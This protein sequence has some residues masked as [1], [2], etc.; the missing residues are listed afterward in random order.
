MNLSDYLGQLNVAVS[1]LQQEWYERFEKGVRKGHELFEGADSEKQKLYMAIFDK[2]VRTE[3]LKAWYGEPEGAS[4]FQGTSVSSLTVPYEVE[5]PLIL[6]SIEEL[7]EALAS[8]YIDRHD[9]HEKDVIR[10][11]LE[12]V[13][14]WI[15]EGLYYG[16]VLGSKMIS[17]AFGLTAPAKSVVFEVDGQLV[18]PHEITSYP[19]SIR[20]AYFEKSHQQI[21]CFKGVDISQVDFEKSLVL[22]DI[23]KPKI[24]KYQG[25]LM[26]GPVL[27]NEIAAVMSRR[28]V[29]L[30]RDKTSGRISPRSLMV[31]IYDTDTPYT[32]HQVAGY[33]GK[34][35]APTLP[36]LTLLGSSG[37]CDAFKW[38]YIYRCSLLAQKIMKS[39]LYS[40]HA[41]KFI[42]FVFFGVLV[43][44][45]AEILLDLDRLSLL[46]YRGDIS[47][48]LEFCYLLPKIDK[49]LKEVDDFDLAIELKTRIR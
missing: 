14:T 27:C 13:D 10:A 45:D 24:K 25:Q 29:K 6:N 4:L 8:A 7:E 42:P 1:P 17:Q 9:R 30:I 48:Y 46:R 49:Q 38:L 35:L 47:P 28:V 43:E 36:G 39:S 22:A 5:N 32:F 21:D 3:E 18:D 16:V 15:A 2:S 40:E 41:R 23:S 33:F 12:T 31:C 44:R 19:Q 26:L 37:T 34:D 11:N 20:K